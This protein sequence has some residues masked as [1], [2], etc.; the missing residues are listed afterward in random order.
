MKNTKLATTMAIAATLATMGT[1]ITTALAKEQEPQ[2]RYVCEKHEDGTDEWFRISK[3]KVVFC[4]A[5]DQGKEVHFLDP[6]GNVY[7]EIMSPLA[8]IELGEFEDVFFE[9]NDPSD[10]TDDV[11]VDCL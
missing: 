11:I 2:T 3:C 1:P 4:L 5:W 8:Q 9:L 7:V 10:P 6:E